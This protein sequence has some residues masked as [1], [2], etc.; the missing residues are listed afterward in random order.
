VSCQVSTKNQ[1]LN[2]FEQHKQP[3]SLLETQPS[4][5]SETSH[6]PKITILKQKHDWHQPFFLV[7]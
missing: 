1:T 6:N 3:L 5:S 7:D 4:Q 2:M